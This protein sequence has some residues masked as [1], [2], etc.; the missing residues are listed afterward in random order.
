MADAVADGEIK[1]GDTH[2]VYG[3]ITF[4]ELGRSLE[5]CIE[6]IERKHPNN[7]EM[8]EKV[9]L[10]SSWIRANSGWLQLTI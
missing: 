8:L 5:E 10:A 9:D 7:L 3:I 6:E 1:H 4:M 2:M